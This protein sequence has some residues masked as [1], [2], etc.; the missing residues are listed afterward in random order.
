M[1]RSKEPSVRRGSTWRHLVNTIE[2]FVCSGDA[3]CRYHCCSGLPIFLVQCKQS[4]SD[5]QTHLLDLNDGLA[6]DSMHHCEEFDEIYEAFAITD[7]IWVQQPVF[8]RT[9][10]Y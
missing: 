8:C 5:E 4:Y 6:V 7:F 3:S 10:F 1:W 2:Q 9:S